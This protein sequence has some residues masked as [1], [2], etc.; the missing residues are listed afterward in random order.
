[1]KRLSILA[2]SMAF[3]TLRARNTLT[4]HDWGQFS[5][6]HIT[7]NIPFFSLTVYTEPRISNQ[8]YLHVFAVFT[9]FSAY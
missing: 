3:F 6:I 1:M 4:L 9:L 5:I 2:E 8:N 7:P